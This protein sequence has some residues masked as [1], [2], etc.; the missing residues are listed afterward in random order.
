MHLE[1]WK[2]N[3]GSLPLY[4]QE[5]EG[6]GGCVNDSF[7]KTGLGRS[8]GKVGYLSSAKIN[9]FCMII[10]YLNIKLAF[11][12]FVYNNSLGPLISTVEQQSCLCLMFSFRDMDLVVKIVD[13]FLDVGYPSMEVSKLP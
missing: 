7:Q 4:S 9:H 5:E 3:C 12:R 11:F 10:Q 2:L 1:Y 6:V 13:G 8:F